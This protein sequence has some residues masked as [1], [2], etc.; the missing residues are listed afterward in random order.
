MFHAE[1]IA[2]QTG[3]VFRVDEFRENNRSVFRPESINQLTNTGN[4]LPAGS[5]FQ[6]GTFIEETVLHVDN[7]Q[8]G[9]AG[10][11]LVHLLDAAIY[12]YVVYVH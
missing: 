4:E 1:W 3:H 10:N 2:A 6:R 9:L 12:L 8:S 7:E 11:E 5:H